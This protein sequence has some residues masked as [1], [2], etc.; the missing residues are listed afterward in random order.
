[1]ETTTTEGASTPESLPEEA[2]GI[3]D[4]K[5][6]RDKSTLIAGYSLLVHSFRAVD[7][8]QNVDANQSN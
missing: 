5:N 2:N 6:D 8:W 4:S 3:G 1:M 7:S